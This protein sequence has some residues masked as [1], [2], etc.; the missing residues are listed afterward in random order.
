M[1]QRKRARRSV[2]LWTI[3]CAGALSAAADAGTLEIPMHAVEANG[4]G[5][6]IGTVRV[7][8]GAK[9]LLFDV[10]LERMPP[11]EHGFHIH[12][13][14]DC[15]AKAQDGTMTAAAAAGGHYDPRKTGRHA[16]PT[17]AGHLGGSSG[18]QG[19]RR[20]PRKRAGARAAA[21]D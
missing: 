21:E 14:A 10:E 12:E 16:G 19:R 3:A 5:A 17:G 11:G 15:G 7:E 6:R 9:G 8:D 13:H 2:A 4:V 1:E 18:H 20:G